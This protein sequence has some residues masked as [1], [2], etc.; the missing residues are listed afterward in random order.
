[1]LHRAAPPAD[2]ISALPA[3]PYLEC[4]QALDAGENLSLDEGPRWLGSRAPLL[5]LLVQGQLDGEPCF[6]LR[7]P[8]R[9]D[10]TDA[11]PI[12]HLYGIPIGRSSRAPEPL[13]M[14]M[15]VE[16]RGLCWDLMWRHISA[17]VWSRLLE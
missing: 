7:R 14:E 13:G 11:L 6:F 1:M 16:L 5:R 12:S 9:S 2:D 3:G 10:F 8:G 17:K 15:D 4:L